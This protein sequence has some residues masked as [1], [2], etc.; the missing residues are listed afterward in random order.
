MVGQSYTDYKYLI[1]LGI[2][3]E[4]ARMV[5]PLSLY[6]EFYWTVN[7]RSLMNFLSLRMGVDAQWEIRQYAEAID[8]FFVEK[9][10]ITWAAWVEN[11]SL[12]P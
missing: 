6:T 1:S 11:N 7:A 9:M 4:M 12:A 3:K 8:K 2:A 5:L 10:P